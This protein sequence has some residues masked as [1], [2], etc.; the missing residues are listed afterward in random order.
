MANEPNGNGNSNANAAS[1]DI[2]TE[3]AFRLF[4]ERTAAGVRPLHQQQV[5]EQC[6]RDAR[7]F[8]AVAA[9][10]AKGDTFDATPENNILSD[11]SAPKLKPTHPINMVSRQFGDRKRIVE[12]A[13]RLEA[14]PTL[15]EL[16]DLDWGKPE[17]ST[18]R[19]LFPSYAAALVAAGTN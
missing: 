11:A 16:P 1:R 14:N 13:K 5:A 15:D 10:A 2:D 7:A 3:R 18:A 6:F 12:I 9:R 17:V 19:A 4:V 8:S